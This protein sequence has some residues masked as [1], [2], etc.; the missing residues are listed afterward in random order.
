MRDLQPYV[1]TYT[2]CNLGEHFFDDKDAWYV[3]EARYHRCFW[4]CNV[5]EHGVY[6]LGEEF[7]DHLKT[8][9]IHGITLESLDR[10][11][12]AF[13][14]PPRERSGKCHLCD[15][16]SDDLKTHVGRHLQR[17]AL[18]ILFQNEDK[19][20]SDADLMDID[21]QKAVRPQSAVSE[22]FVLAARDPREQAEH[23]EA[24]MGALDFAEMDSRRLTIKRSY[25][26][27]SRWILHEPHYLDW[28]D[29]FKV[30]DHHG[31][32]WIKGKPASGK[33]TIMKFLYEQVKSEKRPGIDTLVISF[34]FNAGGVDLERSAT[35]MY[36]SLLFQLLSQAAD[37]QVLLDD[38]NPSTTFDR[39][40]LPLLRELF[41]QVLDRV[42]NRQ[43]ICFVDAL[44]ECPEEEARDM[45]DSFE[46]YCAHAWAIGSRL[47]ICLSSRHLPHISVGTGLQFPLEM[48]D[49]LNKD[50]STYV[51]AELKIGSSRLAQSLKEHIC[52]RSN[53]NFL[54]AVLMVQMSRMEFDRGRVHSL[55]RKLNDLPRDFDELFRN[56]LPR[57]SQ[58]L[59]NLVLVIQWV[60]YARR[61]LSQAELYFALMSEPG[62]VGTE[63]RHEKHISERDMHR[64]ILS[65]SKGFVEFTE[66][67]N[68]TAQLIHHSVREFLLR[69][70]TLIDP[71]PGLHALNPENSHETLRD[72]C[73]KQCDY[74]FHAYDI[75]QLPSGGELCDLFPFLMYG[76]REVLYHAEEAQ[77]LGR[78]QVAFLRNFKWS[79]WV[80]LW[81]IFETIPSR[82][83]ENMGTDPG[84]TAIMGALI[85]LEVPQLQQTWAAWSVRQ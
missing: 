15:E 47:L 5:T 51:N 76:V 65:C 11:G 25:P 16:H 38:I 22:G 48:G 36:R 41:R 82:Q 45:M 19:D 83:M 79:N 40:D 58:D 73:E 39:G 9:H 55:Q 60:L 20:D 6:S 49:G 66:G 77:V 59:L 67:S 32:L 3:H 24:M 71:W 1:C 4:S 12:E 23:R 8:E 7:I 18:F 52:T 33:S 30:E 53:G 61:P 68:P 31:L 62:F 57:D 85:K 80:T 35:G 44:D 17:I 75:Q 14:K 56:M 69:P 72:A 78:S 43:M 64:Y 28:I 21:S 74:I 81:N 2:Q 46:Q 50:I 34:F 42:S 63:V 37:F 26:Q 70:E 54:W 13:R 27:T 84:N 10:A 29:P